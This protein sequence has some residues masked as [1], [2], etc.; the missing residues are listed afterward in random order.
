LR[1]EK[2]EDKNGS[3][4]GHKGGRKRE[5]GSPSDK[6]TSQQNKIEE[7]TKRKKKE[8]PHVRHDSLTEKIKRLLKTFLEDR[9]SLKLDLEGPS[10]SKPMP[11]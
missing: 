8:V 1:R 11:K 10:T 2:E 3:S 7:G 5:Q 9:G 6:K 4:T